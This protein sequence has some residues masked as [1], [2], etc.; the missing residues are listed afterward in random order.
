MKIKETK[1]KKPDINFFISNSNYNESTPLS[2]DAWHAT[3]ND[4]SEAN[5]SKINKSKENEDQKR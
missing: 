3:F 1:G 4:I 2:T 5:L